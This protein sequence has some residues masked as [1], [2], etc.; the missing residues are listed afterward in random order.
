MSES[1]RHEIDIQ[2]PSPHSNSDAL[3]VLQQQQ[4]Q[5]DYIAGH[6]GCIMSACTYMYMHMYLSHDGYTYD[7]ITY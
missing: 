5:Q 4:Q 6:T 2:L 7:I 3:H 1:H